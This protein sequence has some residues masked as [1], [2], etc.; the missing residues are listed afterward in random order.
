M[1]DGPSR[2]TYAIFLYADAGIQWTTGNADGGTYGLGGNA[3]QI[4]FNK[5]GG[6]YEKLSISGKPGVIGVASTKN[7]IGSRHGVYIFKI[8][9]SSIPVQNSKPKLLKMCIYIYIYVYM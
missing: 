4:G 2:T 3:A 9:E 8:S 6:D 5:G 1:T 7:V